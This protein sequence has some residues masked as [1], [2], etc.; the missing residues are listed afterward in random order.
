MNGQWT[1]VLNPTTPKPRSVVG[2]VPAERWAIRKTAMERSG[3]AAS[4]VDEVSRSTGSLRGAFRG[5]R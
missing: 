4:E 5:A 3:A 1:R 2:S